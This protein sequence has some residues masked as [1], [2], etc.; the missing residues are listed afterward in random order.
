MGYI[1]TVPG[2]YGDVGAYITSPEEARQLVARQLDLGVDLVKF[3]LETGYAGVHDL[4]L[5]PP[6]TMAAIVAAAHGRGKRVTAHVTRA[7]ALREVVEAGADEA[8]HMPY[9]AL[10]DDL[11]Q[12]MVAS[13]FAIAAT[14]TVLEAYGALPARRTTWRASWPPAAR[15]PSA[16]TTRAFPRTA[17]T[18][19]SSGCRCTR[20]RGCAR[21]G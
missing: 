1:I 10:P 17:S 9:D 5:L 11:I 19:S 6:E 14:L 20:S 4:P 18:T 3:S 7:W 12:E 16:T 15:S 21:R 2:G 8:A 13:G